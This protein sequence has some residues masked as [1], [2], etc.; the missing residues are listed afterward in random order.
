VN[1][2]S[3]ESVRNQLNSQKA[4]GSGRW[5]LADKNLALAIQNDDR[6]K[7]K[8]FYDERNGD[9]GYRVWQ[10]LCGFSWVREYPDVTTDMNAPFIGI[11]GDRRAITMAVRRPDFSNAAEQLGVPQVMEFFPIEDDETGLQLLGVQWQEVGTGDVYVSC[12]ILF[13]IGSGNQGG[14]PGSVTDNA[15]L[16]LRSA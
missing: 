9:R 10:D 15:G 3:F 11:C 1:L 4:L 6:T 16:L 13:G 7:S 8:L 2:D 14:A 5:A 12:A